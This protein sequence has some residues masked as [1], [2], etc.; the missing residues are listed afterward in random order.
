[1]LTAHANQ[2][3]PIGIE[4]NFTVKATG[5]PYDAA[6]TFAAITPKGR[7]IDIPSEQVLHPSTGNYTAW[8]SSKSMPGLWRIEAYGASDADPVGVQKWDVSPTKIND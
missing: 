5:A 4:I 6:P 3:D 7:K 1:M 8:Y 2:G